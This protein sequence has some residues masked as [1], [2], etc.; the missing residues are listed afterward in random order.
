M[1]LLM[2]L[3]HS[4]YFSLLHKEPCWNQHDSFCILRSDCD[5]LS[6]FA[7]ASGKNLSAALG[8]HSGQEAVYFSALSFLGLEC[9]LCHLY[10]LLIPKILS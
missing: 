10:F 1:F 3:C 9:H 2:F 8:A 5:L 7:P 4:H 6:A